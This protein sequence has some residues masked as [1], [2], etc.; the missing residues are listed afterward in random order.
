[1][2]I[3]IVRVAFF[4]AC[5][6]GRNFLEGLQPFPPNRELEIRKPS[7]V[8]ARMRQARNKAAANWICD[9]NKDYRYRSSLTS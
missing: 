7:D 5:A 3:A 6:A 4:A 2:T 9:L 1:M 8:A